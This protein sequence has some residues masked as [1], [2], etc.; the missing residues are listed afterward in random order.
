ME[1]NNQNE[2]SKNSSII[3]DKMNLNY[4][5]GISINQNDAPIYYYCTEKGVF[6]CGNL[7]NKLMERNED[8]IIE[9]LS[10]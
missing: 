5:I 10:S 4:I 7:L 8:N 3:L 1:K 9:D 2:F 6:A